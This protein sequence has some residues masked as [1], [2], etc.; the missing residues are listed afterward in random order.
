MYG[1][2]FLGYSDKQAY[3]VLPHSEP[4]YLP[5]WGKG[6]AELVGLAK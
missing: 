6:G 4:V 3:H 1:I 2:C 5:S